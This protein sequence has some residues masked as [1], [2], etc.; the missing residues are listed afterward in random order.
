VLSL[1]CGLQHFATLAQ[2]QGRRTFTIRGMESRKLTNQ[3]K[4][5]IAGSYGNLAHIQMTRH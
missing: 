2:S 4:S 3:A 1:A 5:L